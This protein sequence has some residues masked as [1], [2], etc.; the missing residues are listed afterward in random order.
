VGKKHPKKPEIRIGDIFK[1]QYD[2][3]LPENPNPVSSRT[4]ISEKTPFMDGH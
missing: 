1:Y 4:E 3:I 2:G